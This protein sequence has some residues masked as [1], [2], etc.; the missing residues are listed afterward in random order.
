MWQCLNSHLKHPES[1]DHFR[2]QSLSQTNVQIFLQGDDDSFLKFS[3]TSVSNNPALIKDYEMEC[4]QGLPHKQWK[5]GRSNSTQ[6][7]PPGGKSTLDLFFPQ[8]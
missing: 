7:L 2:I 4:S 8:G 3:D 6:L 1:P 5:Q